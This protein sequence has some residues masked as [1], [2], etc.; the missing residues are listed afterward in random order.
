VDLFFA[1]HV[2]SAKEPVAQQELLAQ[3]SA[4]PLQKPEHDIH[5]ALWPDLCSLIK[6]VPNS[7]SG[8][9]QY[10]LWPTLLP[11]HEDIRVRFDEIIVARRNA[12]GWSFIPDHVLLA[13][14]LLEQAGGSATVS[15][16]TMTLKLVC[17]LGGFWRGPVTE[18]RASHDVMQY[19]TRTGDLLH[20][21]EGVRKPTEAEGHA[22]RRITELRHVL[23]QRLTTP[24]PLYAVLI[25]CVASK[26][27]NGTVTSLE[28]L[29]HASR[30]LLPHHRPDVLRY[31]ALAPF[32][33]TLEDDGSY[34]L[35]YAADGALVAQCCEVAS[36]L[37]STPIVA[38]PILVEGICTVL[39]MRCVRL[40]LA[41]ITT[42]FPC[43]I[44]QL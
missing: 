31:V 24:S 16:I 7:G 28:L 6:R 2:A 17:C 44:S 36:R 43:A 9:P 19:I 14:W 30:V 34:S 3:Y 42:L 38:Q 20:A 39:V 25:E 37:R 26:G 29:D 12:L 15:S 40:S 27:P 18:F 4:A 35:G 13:L 22:T 11:P 10:V 8:P 1:L 41:S 5:R 21:K 32:Y 23:R 33:F